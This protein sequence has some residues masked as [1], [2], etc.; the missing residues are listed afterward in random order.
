LQQG[1]AA[2]LHNATSGEYYTTNKG[3]LQEGAPRTLL[4]APRRYGSAA[5][6]PTAYGSAASAPTAY[7]SA[8]SA[9]TAL[10]RR[11]TLQVGYTLVCDTWHVMLQTNLITKTKNDVVVIN[12]F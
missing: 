11:D 5:S 12:N 8:A 10:S 2:K 3:F 1:R 6:A 4:G 7:G 9:P